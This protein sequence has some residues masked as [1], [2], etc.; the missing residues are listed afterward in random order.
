[1]RTVG[2]SQRTIFAELSM[3]QMLCVV[4]GII[5]GGSYTLWQPI[6][7]LALFSIIYFAGLS[8]ALIVFLRQ[9]L[10]NTMKEDE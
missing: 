5:L 4:L 3:E 2:A 9:N 1:M 7:N 10:L 8:T 6:G